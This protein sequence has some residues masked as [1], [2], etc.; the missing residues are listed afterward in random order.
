MAAVSVLSPTPMFVTYPSPDSLDTFA[1]VAVQNIGSW[2]APTGPQVLRIGATSHLVMESYD[3]AQVYLRDQSGFAMFQSSYST[4]GLRTDTQILDLRTDQVP[5]TNEKATVLRTTTDTA[6]WVRG[7]DVGRTVYLSDMQVRSMNSH[8][9]FATNQALGFLINNRTEFADDV[10]I[11]KTTHCLDT[12]L[13]EG[14]TTV[15]GAMIVN[16][17]SIV[18]GSFFSQDV[19]MWQDVFPLPGDPADALT[20]IGYGFLLLIHR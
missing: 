2:N 6:V 10:I 15:N 9:Q 16:N 12:V 13:I 3:D 8:T 1:N 14:N 5:W 11:D 18:N 7:D 4:E 17:N 19:N 20:R